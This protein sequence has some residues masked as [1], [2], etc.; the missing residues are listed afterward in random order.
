MSIVHEEIHHSY[1]DAEIMVTERT[2]G[3]SIEDWYIVH[4]H[5]DSMEIMTPADLRDLGRWLVEHSERIEREYKKNGKPKGA[6]P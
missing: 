4:F 1:L 5:F 6:T 3:E 2:R